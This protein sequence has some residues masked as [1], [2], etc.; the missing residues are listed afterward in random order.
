MEL[1]TNRG[2]GEHVSHVLTAVFDINSGPT[3][4]HQYPAS[5]PGDQNLIAE[6]MLPDQSHARKEDWTVFFLYR[7]PGCTSFEYHIQ[8]IETKLG[9]AKF[10]VLNLVNTKYTRDVKRGAIVKAMCIVTRHPFFHVFKPL[11]ML[12]LDD[13][14]KTESVSSLKNLYDAI[15]GTDLTHMPVFDSYERSILSA[16]SK[17]NMFIEKFEQADTQSM[18]SSLDLNT[19]KKSPDLDNQPRS[20]DLKRESKP[21][22]SSKIGPESG[23]HESSATNIPNLSSSAYSRTQPYHRAQPS[24]QD[25]KDTAARSKPNYY[26]DLKSNGQRLITRNITRDTHFFETRVL[27]HE[28]KIPIKIPTNVEPEEVGSFSVAA[29]AQTMLSVSQP[30]GVLHKELTVY[31]A[32]TPPLLVLINALLT[33]KRILFVGLNNP[34]GQVSERV[35]AACYLASG[36]FLRP[37]TTNAFPYT[38]LSKADEVMSCPGYIAGVKNPAFGHHREWWDIF[39][40]LENNTMRISPEVEGGYVLDKNVAK[41]QGPDYASSLMEPADSKS[42]AA[43]KGKA[44]AFYLKSVASVTNSSDAEFVK[45]VRQMLEDHFSESSVRA[46]CREYVRRFVRIAASYEQHKYGRCAFWPETGSIEHGYVWAHDYQRVSDFYLYGRVIEGWR[47]SQS[48][49]CYVE[50]CR[51]SWPAPPK[52]AVDFEYRMDLLKSGT[53]ST[54]AAGHEFLVLADNVQDDQDITRFIAGTLGS[55]ETGN[56][57][58]VLHYI[59]MGMLHQ[60]PEVRD[61]TVGLIWRIHD[62]PAGR[63]LFAALNPFFVVAYR[64]L[65]SQYIDA[66]GLLRQGDHELTG[67][68]TET[69]ERKTGAPGCSIGDPGF[70]TE[71]PA[72]LTS[73]ESNGSV[74]EP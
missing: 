48:Y 22:G 43:E 52:K 65:L 3:V 31:G 10:Y 24:N 26:I 63:H 66:H 72:R 58:S 71:N 19:Q 23:P 9:A 62:H 1:S 28:M 39:V 56:G 30:F 8:S 60:D 17:S 32:Y 11:L 38:D 70:K 50:D 12:S 69:T 68:K 2:T 20:P 73:I 34:S 54:A 47:R 29:L 7:Q 33:Q 67:C 36:G 55:S 57:N 27:F 59:A 51:R 35:L 45:S 15:N 46:L 4:K 42:A 25:T 64:R 41:E 40:D 61:A 74:I 18:I 13:Y 53:L 5:I 16:Y 49:K 37:F 6:L 44:N 14:F 21:V